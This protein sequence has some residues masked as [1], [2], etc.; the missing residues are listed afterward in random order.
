MSRSRETQE[1]IDREHRDGKDYLERIKMGMEKD[2]IERKERYLRNRE[3]ANFCLAQL[4]H[5]SI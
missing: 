5:V 2:K 3:Y 1:K 4:V